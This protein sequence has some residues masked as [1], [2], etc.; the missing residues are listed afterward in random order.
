MRKLKEMLRL[1]FE[2]GL[3]NRAIARSLSVSHS[4]VSDL[5]G[6]FR[7]AGMTWPLPGDVDEATLEAALYPGNT[8]RSRHRPEPDGTGSTGSSAGR[9]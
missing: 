4:T 9:G 8:G 5:L 2:V 1:H 3:S 6:R 7:S